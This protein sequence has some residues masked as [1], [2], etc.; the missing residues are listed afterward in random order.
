MCILRTAKVKLSKVRISLRPLTEISLNQ[1]L[2]LVF[3]IYSKFSQR[4][5]C[6]I[7]H[8]DSVFSSHCSHTIYILFTTCRQVCLRL[9]HILNATM[10]MAWFTGTSRSMSSLYLTE[11]STTVC[12]P[13]SST[14]SLQT[15]W[16]SVVFS[17]TV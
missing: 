7:A 5:Y 4:K 6:N 12:S 11:G 1:V 15:H 9:S 17:H 16:K 10:L 8:F 3:S 13:S 14:Q 2:H